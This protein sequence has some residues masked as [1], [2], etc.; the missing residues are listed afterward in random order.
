[1]TGRHYLPLR[2]V[3]LVLDALAMS[4]VVLAAAL[5][6]ATIIYAWH[7]SIMA[8]VA[9]QQM[10]WSRKPII[11]VSP[12][13]VGPVTVFLRIQN[14]GAGV[15]RAAK[16]KISSKPAGLA[17]SWA[18]PSLLPL[19]G[20]TLFLPEK[21]SDLM[22]FAGFEKIVA[23]ISFN[24]IEGT[25]YNYTDTLE[26]KDFRES[27]DTAPTVWEESDE[28]RQKSQVKALENIASA[29]KDIKSA[30]KR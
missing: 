7:T 25:P 4:Q 21:I 1:M 20:F 28:D 6:V 12:D 23:E 8:R 3:G 13:L 30:M 19:Q 15:A 14:V 26:L 22:T 18:H 17:L 29:L 5:L 9:K 2:M 11:A 24:D 10:E 16:V 27:M